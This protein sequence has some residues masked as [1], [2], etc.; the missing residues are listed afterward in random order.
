MI[1][2]P[3]EFR[4]TRFPGYFYNVLDKKLYSIKTGELKPL[5]KKKRW[6]SVKL[7]KW[8][9]SHYVVS[10]NGNRHSVSDRYLDMIERN[11]I[12]TEFLKVPKIND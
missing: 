9:E 5:V 7:R 3:F 6:Y 8:V 11:K 4:A 10:V 12:K 2:F 1:V